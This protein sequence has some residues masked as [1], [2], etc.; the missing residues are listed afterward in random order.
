MLGIVAPPSSRYFHTFTDYSILALQ[1]QPLF[2]KNFPLTCEAPG[3]ASPVSSAYFLHSQEGTGKITTREKVGSLFGG[4]G[5][6]HVYIV[7]F[8]GLLKPVENPCG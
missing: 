2:S 1:N 3:F 4:D 6:G 5:L 7:S 8:H